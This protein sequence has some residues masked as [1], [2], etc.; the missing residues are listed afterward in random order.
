MKGAD[1]FTKTHKKSTNPI[2]HTPTTNIPSNTSPPSSHRHASSETP[3]MHATSAVQ[4]LSPSKPFYRN[5]CRY[6]SLL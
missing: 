5:H 1:F 6:C 3:P 4:A 2:F